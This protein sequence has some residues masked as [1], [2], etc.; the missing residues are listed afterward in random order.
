MISQLRKMF[1]GE[2]EDTKLQQVTKRQTDDKQAT[3]KRPTARRT[4]DKIAR[5]TH[6]GSDYN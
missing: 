2:R 6:D 4:D 5:Q 1:G 3:N